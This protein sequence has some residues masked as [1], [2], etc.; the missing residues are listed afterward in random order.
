MI[1]GID[2]KVRLNNATHGW[3]HSPHVMVYL[4]HDDGRVEPVRDLPEV[5][6]TY[7]TIQEALDAGRDR[8]YFNVQAIYGRP[9]DKITLEA[10][11]VPYSR[12]DELRLPRRPEDE[13]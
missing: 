7:R 10:D 2:I 3:G 9:P 6:T 5:A 8:A 4:T 1:K 12:N 11:V 13:Q